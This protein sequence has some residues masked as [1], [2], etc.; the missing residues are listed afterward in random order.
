MFFWHNRI[1][2]ENDVTVDVSAK[3]MPV[4]Y[5]G[6]LI[7]APYSGSEPPFLPEICL[8]GGERLVPRNLEVSDE[9]PE[10][11]ERKIRCRQ[12]FHFCR[13]AE[14]EPAADFYADALLICRCD[15]LRYEFRFSGTPPEKSR[16]AFPFFLPPDPA[17]ALEIRFDGVEAEWCSS[18]GGASVYGP[19]T[20]RKTAF[21]SF[22]SFIGYDV[23]WKHV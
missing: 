20:Q 6:R 15:G 17:L 3:F 11:R 10:I 1:T 18:V 14:Y 5:F 12:R 22:G 8:D 13:C 4:P 19:S 9:V 16:L 2:G 21:V 23:R 7:P